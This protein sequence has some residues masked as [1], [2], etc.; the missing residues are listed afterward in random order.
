MIRYDALMQSAI[1][2]RQIIMYI[3]FHYE[4]KVPLRS[5][6]K[7]TVT[8]LLNHSLILISADYYYLK[9]LLNQ[10]SDSF[11]YSLQ[12]YRYLDVK[13][14]HAMQNHTITIIRPIRCHLIF[15]IVNPTIHNPTLK[16]KP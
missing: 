1:F 6:T 14:Y 7:L 16:S 11:L 10:S 12:F 2:S 13:F 4:E 3:R 8:I 5:L 9:F 15:V